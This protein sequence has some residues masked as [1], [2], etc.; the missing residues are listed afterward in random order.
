MGT[1]VRRAKTS[2]GLWDAFADVDGFVDGVLQELAAIT[3]DGTS[4]SD[5]DPSRR[6]PEPHCARRGWR[7]G[8]SVFVGVDGPRRHRSAVLAHSLLPSM[9]SLHI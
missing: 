2:P 7:S 3:K 4:R 5:R 8:V 6:S 1:A 9:R